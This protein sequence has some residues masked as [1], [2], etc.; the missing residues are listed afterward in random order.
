VLEVTV[1]K[2]AQSTTASKG[3]GWRPDLPDYR[4]YHAHIPETPLKLPESVRL[5]T[6]TYMP[7]VYDQ[8]RLGSCTANA[9]A[10]AIEFDIRRQG[11]T[12]FT[13]SRLFIYYNERVLER[14]QNEDAGAEIRD[15]AKTLHRVGACSEDTWPYDVS[16][17]RTPPPK[18]AYDEASKTKTVSYGRVP[19]H[20]MTTLL[21]SG[22]PF[23]IGFTV[24][25]SF[26]NV[27]DDGV[28]PMPDGDVLGGHA[29]LVCG[30]ATIGNQFYYRVRNSWGDSWGD[31]GYFW[32]PAAYLMNTRLSQDFW[33]IDTVS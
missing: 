16:A 19:R 27:G 12:D 8:L 24:Y 33:A 6:D 3:L 29:V 22:T 7:P 4:D 30:Y 11:L 32:M 9:L 18:A 13:P 5:D 25:S 14:T 21:A 26:Y 15:G 1:N 23:T 2:S 28:M 31:A 20:V 17:F 10:A